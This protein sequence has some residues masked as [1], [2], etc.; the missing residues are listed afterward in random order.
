ME[1]A[2]WPSSE[3]VLVS[4]MFLNVAA[5]ALIYSSEHENDPHWT[6]TCHKTVEQV[7][8]GANQ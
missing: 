6:K 4:A 2:V 7:P 3:C 8:L 1:Q 5:T